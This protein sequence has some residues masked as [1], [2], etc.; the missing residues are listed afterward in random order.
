MSA[1]DKRY[2][3]A[4]S[5]S[6]KKARKENPTQVFPTKYLHTSSPAV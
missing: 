6:K 3:K 4:L 5:Q 1:C 2:H